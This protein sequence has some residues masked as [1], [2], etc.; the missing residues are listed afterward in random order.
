[1][2]L[3]PIALEALRAAMA[4]L[5]PT[6]QDCHG[7]VIARVLE[8]LDGEGRL[9]RT[10]ADRVAGS[11]DKLTQLLAPTQ[12]LQLEDPHDSPLHHRYRVAHDLPLPP[13]GGVL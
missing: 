12:A 1:M 3:S 9:V 13:M 8:V 5:S 2:S 7:D 6:E 4:G 10:D 11:A